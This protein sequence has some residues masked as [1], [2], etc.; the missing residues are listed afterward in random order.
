MLSFCPGRGTKNLVLFPMGSAEDRVQNG[1]GFWL[2]EPMELELVVQDHPLQ[3]F[4]TH[5]LARSNGGQVLEFS[6]QKGPEMPQEFPLHQGIQGRAVAELPLLQVK[7]GGI[8][9]AGIRIKPQVPTELQ[10]K[11]NMEIRGKPMGIQ[12]LK[13]VFQIVEQP[14]VPLLLLYGVAQHFRQKKDQAVLGLLRV[15][16]LVGDRYPDLRKML[17]T[18]LVPVVGHQFQLHQ[19]QEIGRL[20]LSL[21][22]GEHPLQQ[23]GFQAVA[24]RIG[25]DDQT[26]V[27]VFKGREYNGL[28]GGSHGSK[29]QR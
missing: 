5:G 21:P 13:G 25:P 2:P 20:H 19:G 6:A 29:I 4:P 22:G 8:P 7:I 10:Q 27:P 14:R 11:K 18:P 9:Q 17:Q 16:A 23:V 26:A 24:F 3:E 12:P 1:Q 28:G 15:Q